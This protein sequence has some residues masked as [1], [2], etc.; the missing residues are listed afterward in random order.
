MQSGQCIVT[1]KHVDSVLGE[2][3]RIR[4]WQLFGSGSGNYFDPDLAT[5]RIRIWQLF[6]SRSGNDSDPATIPI[7]Q[8][9]GS[10]SGNDS[11]P[12]LYLRYI[13]V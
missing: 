5:I 11:D 7:R 8:L 3:F 2:T 10:R 12:H 13:C 6:G 4:I 9:F 1:Q